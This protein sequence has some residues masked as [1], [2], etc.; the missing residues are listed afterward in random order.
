M[1]LDQNE[2][3]AEQDDKIFIKG[4]VIVMVAAALWWLLFDLINA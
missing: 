3:L 2:R 1:Y 4:V